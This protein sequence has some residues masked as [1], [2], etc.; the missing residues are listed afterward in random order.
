MPVGIVALGVVVSLQPATSNTLTVLS[1]SP[2]QIS[3]LSRISTPSGPDVL[4]FPVAP[5]NCPWPQ[6]PRNVRSWVSTKSTALL[7]RS[8]RTYRPIAGSTKLMSNEFKGFAVTPSRLPIVTAAI[9]LK[10]SES[11]CAS[12]TADVSSHG[13]SSAVENV[14]SL[15]ILDMLH[16][17]VSFLINR[18]DFRLL[19]GFLCCCGSPFSK[20]STP[21]HIVRRH[22]IPLHRRYDTRLLRRYDILSCRLLIGSC[23]VVELLSRKSRHRLARLLRRYEISYG[24]LGGY[25]ISH[26]R[27]ADMISSHGCLGDM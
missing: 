25:D 23:A 26:G 6:N 17:L 14:S 1:P 21:T 18:T 5:A 24:R 3:R 8:P 4:L 12:T 22:D 9:G 19:I 13:A 27:F 16:S 10:T 11:T 20:V 15:V 2:T 7:V